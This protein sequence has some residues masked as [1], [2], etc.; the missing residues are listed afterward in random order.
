MDA[1]VPAMSLYDSQTGHL[2]ASKKAEVRRL[3]HIPPAVVTGL[4]ANVF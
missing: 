2:L 4:I 3:L 1:T